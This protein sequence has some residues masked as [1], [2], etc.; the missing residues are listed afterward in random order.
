M[1]TDQTERYDRIAEGYARW[2]APVLAPAVAELLDAARAGDLAGGRAAHR[3]RDRDR[4]AGA[5]RPR[6]LAGRV[7]RRRRCVGRDGRRGRSPRPIVCC[8]A[9]TAGASGRSSRSPTR[10]RSATARS[11]VRSRRSSSS[12]SRTGRGPCARLGASSSRAATLAYVSWLEDDR[13]FAPD[14]DVRR[15]PRRVRLRG[16]RRTDGRSGDIPSVERAAGELRRAGFS[17]VDR[18]RRSCSSTAF[19]VE[20]YIAFLVEFDEETLFAELE[21]DRPR[22]APRHAP[23]AL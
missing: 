12:S 8:R 16:A 22:A 10:C 18:P 3:H 9:P 2:W 17:D 11:T 1:A 4:P 13:V 19:T 5:R 14:R 21:P 7:D 20:G 6:S 15:R 23:R